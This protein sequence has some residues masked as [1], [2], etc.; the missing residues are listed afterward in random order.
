MDSGIVRK[1]ESEG[2]CGAQG[3]IEQFRK[4]SLLFSCTWSHSRHVESYLVWPGE[5]FFTCGW[6]PPKP[7][8]SVQLDGKWNRELEN[9]IIS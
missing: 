2:K 8:I 6:V 4:S 7:P 9:V 1:P 5:P 3:L